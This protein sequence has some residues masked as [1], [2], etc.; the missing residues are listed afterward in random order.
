MKEPEMKQL[1]TWIKEVLNLCLKAQDENGLKKPE[2]QAALNKI[3]QS[4]IKL[5]K[6]FPVPAISHWY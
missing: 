1:A 5:S 4:V 3:H 2:I 6:K